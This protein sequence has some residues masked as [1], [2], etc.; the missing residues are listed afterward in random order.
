MLELDQNNKTNCSN[1]LTRLNALWQERLEYVANFR[2][3]NLGLSTLVL[4]LVMTAFVRVP[5]YRKQRKAVIVLGATLCV[6]ISQGISLAS[7]PSQ[8]KPYRMDGTCLRF[9]VSRVTF[10]RMLIF[11][12]PWMDIA[13]ELLFQRFYLD[14]IRQ[15]HLV[16][17]QLGFF[18]FHGTI[19][20]R[21]LI[22]IFQKL[23]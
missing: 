14:K 13:F 9:L 18:I 12:I 17:A 19:Q 1:C 3:H 21:I 2:L 22:H 16:I 7:T 20:V 10:A 5:R 23:I 11:A 4:L 15:I 8:G 6:C